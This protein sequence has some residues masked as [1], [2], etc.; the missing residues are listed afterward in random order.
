M[1]DVEDVL[2]LIRADPP[3]WARV[4]GAV[5]ELIRED[6]DVSDDELGQVAVRLAAT[7]P[8]LP[9][10]TSTSRPSG[11]CSGRRSTR[12]GDR[13]W[14]TEPH[15]TR[16][17]PGRQ[18]ALSPAIESADASATPAPATAPTSTQPSTKTPD[19]VTNESPV[20]IP[21]GRT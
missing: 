14:R 20:R 19:G 3:L 8:D 7:L 15:R 10:T 4:R 1:D 6:E 12:S 13:R 5:D 11:G 21:V 9:E 18:R 2:E 16:S 17:S